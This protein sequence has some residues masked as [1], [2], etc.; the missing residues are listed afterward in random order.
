MCVQ[1]ADDADAG[2]DVKR[3]KLE[4]GGDAGGGAVTA[5]QLKAVLRKH[6]GLPTRALL[7]H[8]KGSIDT[9]AQKQAFR[10]LLKAHT[11]VVERDGKKVVVLKS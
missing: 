10:A 8:F 5:G 3:V 2:D 7:K 1:R 11:R 6:G 9:D 4:E